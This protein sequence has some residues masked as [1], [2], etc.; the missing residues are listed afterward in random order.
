MNKDD[1]IRK[2]TSRKFWMAV[3]SFVTLLV[4]AFGRS[5]SEAAQVSAII[6]AGATVLSYIIGEGM[7][8]AARE[9][10][11]EDAEEYTE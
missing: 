1:L 4:I 2:L 5:E 10:S 9:G 7:I 8:D 3:C 11:S 6:M